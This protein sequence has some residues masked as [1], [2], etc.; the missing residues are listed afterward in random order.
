MNSAGT[1]VQA[2]DAL[3][4][5]IRRQAVAVRRSADVKNSA[6]VRWPDPQSPSG[7]IGKKRAARVRNLRAG[8]G[9]KWRGGFCPSSCRVTLLIHTRQ[10]LLCMLPSMQIKACC[11]ARCHSSPGQQA[12]PVPGRPEAHNK[13]T[14]VFQHGF[15]PNRPCSFRLPPRPGACLSMPGVGAQ[16]TNKGEPQW[17]ML[18]FIRWC[19]QARQA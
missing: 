11:A 15:D 6:H 9:Q 17:G 19:Q 16:L 2:D 7:V 18:I 8:A 3:A 14:G 12:P 5:I 10:A 1:V 13:A 4:S